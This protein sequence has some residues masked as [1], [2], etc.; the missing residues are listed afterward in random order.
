MSTRMRMSGSIVILGL[1]LGVVPVAF[2]AEAPAAAGTEK[3][4]SCHADVAK[5]FGSTKHGKAAYYGVQGAGCVSC[6]GES[7]KHAGSGD[8]ADAFNP[9]KADPEKVNETCLECHSK[10]KALMF[11]NGSAHSNNELGCVACHSVHGGKDKLLKAADDKAVCFTCHKNVRAA[12]FA[13]S[14]HPMR[15]SSNPKGEGKMTCASCH[16]PHGSESEKL[17]SAKS[18][19]DKCYECHTEKKAPLLW[20]HS[21]VKEDCLTCHAAHGAANDKLLTV[22]PPRL[23]QSCHMQG[24]HQS[25]T[26][27]VNSVYAIGRSCLNCHPMVHG[28]NSP[29]GPVLQR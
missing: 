4:Q 2:G 15:D 17:I 23:C 28:S 26:L 9:A 14:K 24:R 18:V 3:C 1:A 7:E 5:A 20:E 6:H 12:M 27:D 19:N 13:R 21:P 11:W 8:K 25:G 10:T 29:S 22:R 16:N